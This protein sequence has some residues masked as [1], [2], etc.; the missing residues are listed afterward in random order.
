MIKTN[1]LSIEKVTRKDLES[2]HKLNSIPEVDKFNTLGIPDSFET[3]KKFIEPL[4]LEMEKETISR[5]TFKVLF[6][7]K[8]IGLAGIVG[9]NPK[10]KKAEIWFK[11]NPSFWNKGFATET[12]NALITFCFNEM[13]LHR[14]EAGCAIGNIASKKVLEKCGF[15]IEGT[16]RQNLPLKTG[17]SDNHEYSILIEEFT[18]N[19]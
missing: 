5:Y 17:W 11:F 1:R 6:E 14:I 18:N 3:T 8:F 13:K 7:N 10:Y 9:G 16:Q 2:I 19:K 15:I 12:T 4:I